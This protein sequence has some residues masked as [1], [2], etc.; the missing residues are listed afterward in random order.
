MTA[1]TRRVGVRARGFATRRADV[2]EREHVARVLGSRLSQTDDAD[3]SLGIFQRLHGASFAEEVVT[4]TA[5][6]VEEGD[7]HG[8]ARAGGAG[9]DLGGGVGVARRHC[10]GLAAARLAVRETGGVRAAALEAELDEGADGLLVHLGVGGGLAEGAVEGEGGGFDAAGAVDARL[11]LVHHHVAAVE[12]GDD[13]DRLERQL[14]GDEGA[15]AHHDRHLGLALVRAGAG[16]VGGAAAEDAVAL[17]LHH[18]RETHALEVNAVGLALLL[19]RSLLAERLETTSLATLRDELHLGG[20]RAMRWR[21]GR[22]GVRGRVEGGVARAGADRDSNAPR[23]PSASDVQN[24][25]TT[26]HLVDARRLG[27]GGGHHRARRRGGSRDSN[28]RTGASRV[29]RR[30]SRS[31]VNARDVTSEETTTTEPAGARGAALLSTQKSVMTSAPPPV[32]PVRAARAPPCAAASPWRARRSSRCWSSD[33]RRRSRRIWTRP[34]TWR[35]AIRWATPRTAPPRLVLACLAS[36]TAPRPARLS[37]AWAPAASAARTAATSPGGT[38][39]SA[40]TC[41][42]PPRTPSLRFA[43]TDAPPSSPP[44]P[45]TRASIPSLPATT[46]R[47]RTPPPPPPR[48]P[49]HPARAASSPRTAPAASTARSTP[50][51]G[52]STTPPRSPPTRTFASRRCSSPRSSPAATARAPSPSASSVSSPRTTATEPARSP[53]CSASKTP[54]RPSTSPPWTPEVPARRGA[55]PPALDSA[56]TTSSSAAAKRAPEASTCTSRAS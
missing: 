22:T 33:H 21:G 15:L 26:A 38:F 12:A 32:C 45:R 54:S 23:V 50:A 24:R 20:G 3:A 10:V 13:V 9:G 19:Q 30:A 42:V 4:L 52:T 39:A 31:A 47:A 18:A 14:L 29:R 25:R 35:G 55:S 41:T 44:S 34:R 36:T 17:S 5:V 11:G 1:R 46:A 49:P 48:T 16:E 2:G 7:P 27:L 37:G 28:A 6:Y 51:R 8:V 43:W 53:S 40:R 56:T